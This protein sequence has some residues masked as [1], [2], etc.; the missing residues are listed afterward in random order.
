MMR[1]LIG[2]SIHFRFLMLAIAAVLVVIGVAQLRQMPVDVLP[3]FAPPYVEVQTE[4]LG[5]STDEVESLISLNLE[6]LLN[7][8]PWLESIHSTSVPGLSSLVLVFEPGT[9]VVRARQLV[10]ERL[11]L[12]YTLPNVSKPPVILQPLSATSRVM[13][14]GLS[15]R[16]TS[17]IDMSVLARWN[18]RPALLAVPGV[19]NVSVWGM[20]ERQLQV[21]VDP[22]QLRTADV[23]LDQIV[24]AAGD[25]VWVS[26]LTFLN[27]STPGS[28]GWVDTPQQRLEVR[29]D[30]PILEAGDLAKVAV[31]GTS[32]R[33]GDVAQVVEDH[34][35]L[36][37]DAVLTNGPGLL[38]VVEKFPGANTLDVTRGVEATLNELKPG[39]SG[40]DI[41]TSLF[42]P[43][44]F[45][46]EAISNL[47]LA[48]IIGALLAIFVLGAFLWDWRV[49]LISLLAVALSLT[50]AALV[51]YA[52]GTTMNTM[53]LA[54][55]VIAVGLIIDDAVVDMD[56]I[57]GRLRRYR[58]KVGARTVTEA[59]IDASLQMRRPLIYATLVMILAISP[60][61]FLEGVARSFFGPL[62]FSYAL[63]LAASMVVALTLTPALSFILLSRGPI[64]R[65][66]SPLVRRLRGGYESALGRILGMLRPVAIATVGL[67]VVAILV[68]PLLGQSLLPPFRDA[69]LVVKW[70][71]APGT[72]HPEMYRLA[73]Q[74][75]AALQNVPGVAK[76]TGQIGRAV[77]GDQVVGIN[78]AQLWISIDPSA[79]QD[80]IRASI[81]RLVDG[82]PGFV[83]DADTYVS[84][85][86][87]QVLAGPTDDIVVR[88]FGPSWET[89]EAKAD[90]VRTALSTIDGASYVHGE[91]DIREPYLQIEVD[92]AR[93]ERFGLK[94]G[95]VRRAAS[96][97]LAGLQVG[98][99][100][101][102]QKTFEVVVWGTPE[103][104]NSLTSIRELLIDSPNGGHVRLEDVADVRVAST[105]T[106]VN[107][108]AVSRRMDI[109]LTI[110]GRDPAAVV[111]D[112]ED[113]L[114]AVDFP[115]EY[116][117]ELL[118]EYAERQAAQSRLLGFALA[119]LIGIFLLL[120]AAFG[121]WRLASLLLVTLPMALV[122]GVLAALLGGGVLS[123]G[124]LVG[125]VTVL[126]IAA[127]NGIM[128]INHYQHL[129]RE[130]G[131]PFGPELV[132]R[133]ARERLSP[134]LMTSLVVALALLPLIIAGDRPGL[135]IVR[136][137]A[138]VILGGLV[139]STLLTLFVLPILYLGLRNTDGRSYDLRRLSWPW[140]GVKGDN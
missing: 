58:Q 25:A 6:E 116:H 46:D 132:L 19:A 77:Q 44:S 52:T 18:I 87:Q 134:I 16:D 68:F 71:G 123:I 17:L 54:G 59:I 125:F 86:V 31:G 130:E 127:R 140:R 38:L 20:R 56:H 107:R 94:P 133:G 9:D 85:T 73:S 131:E 135:E 43:A 5:L 53:V 55:L 13:L 30:Q 27:A 21:Q 119:A 108:D 60:V 42:R 121:S 11:S 101:E 39:L 26:P 8:T 96:T 110:S 79:D 103:T 69:D 115:L 10:A 83:A 37:G 105:R 109:G 32:L 51:L 67:L 62:A 47:A 88:V 24:E 33:L 91:P 98:T 113:R 63:A 22:E 138:I 120:Q 78:S 2:T 139:T 75:S 106:V 45:I 84:D 82:Y 15:S 57:V 61:F 23:T 129:E 81:D 99:L 14:V 97:Y 36:I 12:A 92:L 48:L 95:D 137:M 126:G 76:V 29:H 70:N 28:G 104:R 90:E 112:V 89:L 93:A 124:S 1:A 80:A 3:E 122:G 65:R 72:S 128:L 50:A 4:A 35:P 7:G 102:E 136:P 49:A 117:A 114:A 41:D 74:A 100:F 66:E 34:Q 118:G 111:A 40:I 64:T